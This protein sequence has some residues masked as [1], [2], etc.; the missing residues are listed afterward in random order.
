MALNPT[1]SPLSLAGAQP[2][3]PPLSLVSAQPHFPPLNLVQFNNILY[4]KHWA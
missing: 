4:L 1:F 3:L 2:H